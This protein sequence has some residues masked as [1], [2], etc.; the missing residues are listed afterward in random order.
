[1]TVQNCC[2]I[3]L[4]SRTAALMEFGDGVFGNG[5]T[6]EVLPANELTRDSAWQF[7]DSIVH[8]FAAI[9]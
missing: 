9:A 2:L 1:M 7:S 4:P 6:I 8:S 5:P 3:G